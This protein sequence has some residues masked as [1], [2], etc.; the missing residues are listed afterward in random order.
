MLGYSGEPYLMVSAAGA[1]ENVRSPALYLN[2]SA[3]AGLVYM[4]P[5]TSAG[6]PPAWRLICRCDTVR[7][8]DHRIHWSGTGQPTAVA[9]APDQ[10]HL[11]DTWHIYARLGSQPL[12]VSGTLEWVPGPSPVV[13]VLAAGGFAVLAGSI[14]FVRRW[15]VP[16]A[17]GL[18]LLVAA[19]MA[20]AV[21]LVSGRSGAL[22]TQLGAIPDDGIVTAILWVGAIAIAVL[23]LNG[24]VGAAFGT[25]TSG[26]LI[27]VVSAGPSIG[28]WWHSQVV[29]AYSAGVERFT[30]AAT[31]GFGAGLAVAG[32]V[33][34][35]RLDAPSGPPGEATHVRGADETVRR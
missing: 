13:W 27:A 28:S 19:D 17:A 1:W 29:T 32:W 35:R 3:T 24:R 10:V 4:P 18:L 33:Q 11:I 22:A 30:I 9:A 15:R 12:D 20:R 21:G 14:A 16:L 5:G 2:R 23:A 26:L 6:A 8:H 25:A 31:I 34:L 7:W